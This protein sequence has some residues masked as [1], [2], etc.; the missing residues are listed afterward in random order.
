MDLFGIDLSGAAEDMFA[1][2]GG[3]WTQYADAATDFG[4]AAGGDYFT[5]ILDGGANALGSGMFG[6]DDSSMGSLFD[7]DLDSATKALMSS[8]GQM[9]ADGSITGIGPLDH[10]L[11]K[12][13]QNLGE[14]WEKD[15]LALIST[16]IG[17]LGKID[18]MRKQHDNRGYGT[19]GASAMIGA[20]P[21]RA[22][23]AYRGANRP[24]VDMAGAVAP[25]GGAP[26][27]GPVGALSQVK[28]VQIPIKR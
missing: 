17:I 21:P 4:G 26:K 2:G 25:A 10:V 8:G 3:D 24:A 27:P 14:R 28:P 16:G 23:D 6:T 15:P 7:I 20:A 5:Q 19:G 9:Q 13:G 18:A 1:E 12:V 22:E 11:R